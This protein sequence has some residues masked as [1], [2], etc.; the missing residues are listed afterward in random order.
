MP[1]EPLILSFDTSGAYIAAA[2]LRGE[3]V[4]GKRVEEMKKGQ[5]ERLIP[6]LEELLDE[7]GVCWADL[8]A[9][10]VGTGPGNFTGIRISVSAAR[11][12]ALGLGVPALGVSLFEALSEGREGRFALPA[13]RGHVYAQ[14]LR[15]GMALSDLAQEPGE[16]AP[17]NPFEIVPAIA[18]LAARKLAA[19]ETASPK[20]LY[21]RPADAAPARD[22]PPRILA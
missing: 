8:A 21:A 16:A 22:A 19:G 12:L 14:T 13:P 9:L 15:D 10:G 7:T 20:P 17:V 6:L 5:A 2:L 3:V 1:S 4:I 11:G 18:R